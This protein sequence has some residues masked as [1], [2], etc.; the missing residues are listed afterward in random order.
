[1]IIW[2]I[3]TININME[4]NPIHGESPGIPHFIGVHAAHHPT[5]DGSFSSSL[6]KSSPAETML[7]ADRAWLTF[8]AFGHVFFDTCMVYLEMP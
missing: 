8:P 6:A 4:V 1:M 3:A 7:P 2:L 5:F